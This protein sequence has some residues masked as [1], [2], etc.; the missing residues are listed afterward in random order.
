LNVFISYRRDDSAVATRLLYTELVA[1]F[2]ADAVFMDVDNI[3]YGDAF[4]AVI[5]ERLARADVVV[6]VI[7]PRWHEII[8]QRQRG[9]DWVR[10]EV[11]QSLALKRAS[12]Q[13]AQPSAERPGRP[14]IIP[15]QLDDTL[16]P[17]PDL[18][19][20]IAALQPLNAL[21]IRKAAL[22]TGI[23]ELVQA[24]QGYRH[25]DHA[26]EVSLSQ[27]LGRHVRWWAPLLAVAVFLGAWTGLL[28]LMTWDTRLAGA[29]ISWAGKPGGESPATGVVMVVIDQRTV[30][31]VGRDF[32]PS[33]RREHGL[34]IEQ[35]A[36]AGAKVVALDIFM[37]NPAD[38]AADAALVRSLGAVRGRLRVVLGVLNLGA[39]GGPA[40][41]S[42]FKPLVSWGVACVGTRLGRTM[43]VPVV[44][45]PLRPA[46]GTPGT[47]LWP[48]LGLAAFSG[49][50]LIDQL[51]TVA[52]TLQVHVEHEQRN[53]RLD[54]FSLETVVARNDCGLL[55]AGDRVASQW[56]ALSAA[57]KPD[58]PRLAYEDLLRGDSAAL[59]A[60]QGRVVLV[61]VM[62]GKE[63]TVT[64]SGQ[65]PGESVFASELIAAQVQALQQGRTV[66]SAGALLQWGWTTLLTALGA[67]LW[68]SLRKRAQGVRLLA[69]GVSAAA[70][71]VVSLWWLRAEQQ[72][73]PPHHGVLAL[74][75]GAGL[76]AWLI[77]RNNLR[78]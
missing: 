76:A 75:L 49:G 33:W 40:I 8:E 15:V 61:S 44:V 42:Q 69:L 3:G 20:D 74:L 64:L 59:K 18:P 1:R 51:D 12:L 58:V 28:D 39:D 34:V 16:W 43:L 56:A 70:V 23:D 57:A 63:D 53:Q 19:Q 26:Q 66:R 46:T 36:A 30:K 77:R 29:A 5:D 32:G 2:G 62:L 71:V 41:A 60:L 6:V 22:K 25:E 9:D 27:R 38:P 68:M 24:V 35:A 73:L 54:I 31:S 11:A 78:R 14:R 7:G 67:S 17:G 4:A 55:Q 45:Q 47:V 65:A 72:L 48:S 10:H 37:P 52:Q 13:G 21:P 50:G